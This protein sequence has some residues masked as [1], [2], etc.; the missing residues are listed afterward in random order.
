MFCHYPSAKVPRIPVESIN[1]FDKKQIFK[2]NK[3]GLGRG[4]QICERKTVLDLSLLDYI[5]KSPS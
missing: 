2:R 3:E 4:N 1:M 5:S